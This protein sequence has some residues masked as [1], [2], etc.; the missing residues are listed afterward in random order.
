MVVIGVSSSLFEET[1]LQADEATYS[2]SQGNTTMRLEIN[3]WG[4][5]ALG[6]YSRLL[7]AAFLYE[8]TGLY[9]SKKYLMGFGAGDITSGCYKLFWFIYEFDLFH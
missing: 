7:Y 6:I 8:V 9:F 4:N 2:R 1:K 3:L 5:P